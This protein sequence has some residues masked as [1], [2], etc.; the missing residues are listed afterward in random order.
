MITLLNQQSDIDDVLREQVD[1]FE[2]LVVCLRRIDGSAHA[3]EKCG[4]VGR[5]ADRQDWDLLV[6]YLLGLGLGLR[7]GLCLQVV[8]WK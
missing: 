3:I 2:E 6:M 8:V 4:M 7:L 5:S 1:E